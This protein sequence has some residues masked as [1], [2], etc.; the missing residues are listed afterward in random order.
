MKLMISLLFFFCG[1]VAA[2]SMNDLFPYAAQSHASDGKIKMEED[3][4]IGGTNNARLDF[5]SG[6]FKGSSRCDDKPCSLSYKSGPKVNLPAYQADS[7]S[8]PADFKATSS[9][10]E[11]KCEQGN[12]SDSRSQFKSIKIEKGCSAVLTGGHDEYRI[13]DKLEVKSGGE[14]TL[15]AG[16][17]WLGELDIDGGRLHLPASGQVNFYVNGD[18]NIKDAGAL[19]NA[20]FNIYAPDDDIK[21]E[22]SSQLLGDAFTNKKL[23]LKDAAQ[24]T[25]AI[26]ADTLKLD[27]TLNLSGGEYSLHKIELKKNARLH[28]TGAVI[29]NIESK[30]KLEED[31]V[32]GN[33]SKSVRLY[34][35]GGEDKDA[36]DD[37]DKG[38]ADLKKNSRLYGFVYVQGKLKLHEGAGVYGAVNVVDL[39]MKKNSAI[40]FGTFSLS[41]RRDIGY[42]DGEENNAAIITVNGATSRFKVEYGSGELAYEVAGEKSGYSILNNG[43]IYSLPADTE[44]YIRHNQAR[45]VDL[46][47]TEMSDSEE[48]LSS[49]KVTLAFVPYQ[50]EVQPGINCPST[51]H[52]FNY[53]IHAGCSVLAKA[54]EP[55]SVSLSFIGY[56]VNGINDEVGDK[57]LE[58]SFNQPE[59][60]TITELNT[61]VVNHPLTTFDM[62]IG[63]TQVA[64]VQAVVADHCAVY[65][66][67]CGDKLTKGSDAVIGRTVPAALDVVT[68]AAGQIAGN[69][70]YAGKA[71]AFTT[72]PGFTVQAVDI[73]GDPLPSYSGE[74][75]G[76]LTAD[77]I[78]LALMIPDD[79]FLDGMT[80]P[81]TVQWDDN[82]QHRILV[83]NN[84]L[85]FPK[86][87]TPFDAKLINVPLELNIAIESDAVDDE[88]LILPPDQNNRETLVED[89]NAELRYGQLMISDLTLATE[90]EGTMPV[91]LQYFDQYG[92]LIDDPDFDLSTQSASLVV[93]PENGAVLPGLTQTAD[94]IDVDAYAEAAE[95]Q[96]RA[97]VADWLKTTGEAAL[98]DPAATLSISAGET[99]LRGHDRII[100]RREAIR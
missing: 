84:E 6:D 35:Y 47:L 61:N 70:V 77:N 53:S 81:V 87:S 27:G 76:G 66:N 40:N 86:E 29:L 95:F 65:A 94:G 71:V 39:E 54:G 56:G 24:L 15:T 96:I 43:D 4:I 8:F 57:I 17:Y 5:Y 79:S 62:N 92:T 85:S 25:G 58:Y 26:R 100:Y 52:D 22:G 93:E 34:V 80:M 11:F 64:L 63:F 2:Q 14:L 41:A 32:L 10:L 18:V 88:P 13:K 60:V 44:I 91:Y 38:D 48:E 51:L 21:L 12:S 90:T 74:F 31:S 23:E 97:D 36:D 98:L 1:A 82:G 16:D 78:S 37:P 49:D 99:P 46:V 55:K 19:G 33:A 28:T 69:H 72:Q 83:T 42:V 45:N 7:I 59:N 3:A 68:S 75:A 67:N 30:L 89:A 20:D 9:S 50:I 73:N